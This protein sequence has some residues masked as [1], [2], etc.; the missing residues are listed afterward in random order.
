[1]AAHPDDECMFFGPTLASLA[2]AGA[3]LWLLCLS[4]GA[5]IAP[6]AHLH[7]TLQRVHAHL[8]YI[9]CGMNS[10]EL[11]FMYCICQAYVRIHTLSVYM[12]SCMPPH[13][14]VCPAAGLPAWQ[15][16]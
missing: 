12:T 4:V 3:E 13:H 15:M 1:M 11:H 7:L 16:S 5:T 2:A 14:N 9:S 10:Q 6:H 8:I